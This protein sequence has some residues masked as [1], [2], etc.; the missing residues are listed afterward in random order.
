MYDLNDTE[1]M[2]ASEIIPDGTFA[3]VTMTIRPGGM[4]GLSEID[5]ALLKPS[6]SAGSDVLQLDCEFVV[7][8]GPHAKR[9]FWHPFTISGGKVDENGVSAGWNISKRMFRAMI[10]SALGLDPKDMSD[11]AKGKRQLRGLADLSGI[12]F[13]AK[14]MTESSTGYADKNRLDRPVLP[15]EK[16]WALIMDG[17][18]V[19]PS[20]TPRKKEHKAAPAPAAGQPAWQQLGASAPT[21]SVA[22]TAAAPAWGQAAQQQPAAPVPQPVAKAAGPAWLNT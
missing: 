17:K 20:P 19:P 2:R 11:E 10:D 21:A 12:T 6:A 8:E 4:N 14:I 3:K 15:N 1:P 5:H 18:D 16:E 13:V 22:P 9:K 7:A